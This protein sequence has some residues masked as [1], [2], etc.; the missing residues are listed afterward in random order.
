ML[1]IRLQRTGREN[2]PTYRIVVAEKARPVKGK[3]QEII[4]HYLPAQ[5]NP[6]FQC[7]TERVSF[8]VGRGAIPSD[9][10]AR[11]LK[12]N[13]VAGMEKFIVRYTKQRKKGEEPAPPAAPAAPAP[14]PA[15]ETVA[16]G[17]GDKPAA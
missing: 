10:L 17:E 4:G 5:K 15:A 13:G 12:K 1:V 7:D 8:W 6:V 2:L 3:Y 16:P 14:A 11:L 9:T